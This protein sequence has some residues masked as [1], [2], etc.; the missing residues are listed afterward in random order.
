MIKLRQQLNEDFD[1]HSERINAQN[2]AIAQVQV[3][4]EQ[5]QDELSATNQGLTSLQH[6][7]TA[8]QH[9]MTSMQHAMTAMQEALA[10]TQTSVASAHRRI[11][12]GNHNFK[13]F[14]AAHH[15]SQNSWREYGKRF[16]CTLDVVQAALLTG[17]IETASRFERVENRLNSVKER[18]GGAA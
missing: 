16:G 15:S 6:G 8:M 3:S 13:V 17:E 10:V 1:T 7:T 4:L 12:E 14:A 11:S 9:A 5:V 18:L 2:L